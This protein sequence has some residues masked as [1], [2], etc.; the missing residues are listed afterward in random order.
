MENKKTIS[1][2]KSKAWYRLVK[3]FFF[4]ALLIVLGIFGF[5]AFSSKPY[6]TI[7]QYNSKIVCNN[8]K[9]YKAGDHGIGIYLPQV[10]SVIRGADNPADAQVLCVE[11]GSFV[12]EAVSMDEWTKLTS[13]TP[14]YKIE[15]VEKTVGNWWSFIGYIVLA[16]FIILAIF[17]AIRRIFYYIVLGSIKPKNK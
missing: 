12:P 8:G 13:P 9:E 2:L 5:I 16:L 4:L 17:E 15:I 10:F 11:G 1:Y 3:V 14:L 6:T 7:D